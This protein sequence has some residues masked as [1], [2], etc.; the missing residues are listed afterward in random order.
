MLTNREWGSLILIGVGIV[1]LLTWPK[2]RPAVLNGL[3]DVLRSFH[4]KLIVSFLVM[5]AWIAGC[6]ALG[7][8]VGLWDWDL[9][10]DSVII[11]LT[12][13]IPM[14]FRISRAKTGGVIVRRIVLD[15][16]GI[17]TL[18]AFY[19]NVEPFPLWAEVLIQAFTTFIAMLNVA[20]RDKEHPGVQRFFN[21]VLGLVGVGS[22]VWTTV[23]L[24][25]DWGALDWSELLRSFLLTL[26]LPALLLPLF[27]V[28]AFLMTIEVLMVRLPILTPDRT[29]PRRRVR[30]AII[31]GLHFRVKL[32]SRFDGRYNKVAVLTTF[33]ETV[34]FRRS[35]RADVQREDAQE[36]HR[37]ETLQANTGRTGTDAEGAQLDRREFS[38]TKDR[39][40]W[41]STCEMGQYPNRDNHYWSDADGLTDLMVDPARHGLPDD[42]GFT[43]QTTPDGQKWR[44]WRVLPSGWVLGMGGAGWRSE[45]V[46]TGAKPPTSWPGDGDPRWTDKMTSPDLP[47]DW[48][49][50]DDPVVA[51]VKP[52]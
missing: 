33:R 11:T 32:V 6:L 13:A 48:T 9:L 35:F 25:Q 47:A 26:W 24:V 16:V 43:V 31:L 4:W 52:L 7:H 46:Y 20:A 30:L 3:P 2:T 37:V 19:L 29:P 42:H 14:L 50:D 40:D 38:V 28:G 44:S 22:I 45:W 15:A 34:R 18:L 21:V 27:Y 17:A 12:F 49:K 39:L 10:K 23:A 36:R 41:I 8:L 1:A 51:A 5:F